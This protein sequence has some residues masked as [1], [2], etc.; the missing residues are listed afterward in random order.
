[1]KSPEIT[2]ALIK[3][4]AVRNLP[5]FQAVRKIIEENF[6]VLLEKEVLITSHLAQNFYSEHR[7]RFFYNRLIT[8][9]G[10]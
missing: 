10:R 7:E 4:H 9:I 3:P 6:K 8:S 2:L 1:M 5:V